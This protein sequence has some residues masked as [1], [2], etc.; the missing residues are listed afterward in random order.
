M[1][2]I[3]GNSSNRKRMQ[4]SFQNGSNLLFFT[5]LLKDWRVDR[6]Q[7]K[8]FL[9]CGWSNIF[10]L[11]FQKVCHVLCLSCSPVFVSPSIKLSGYI[12]HSYFLYS[13]LS[14][15]K[16][17]YK[18]LL[19]SLSESGRV[20]IE[21]SICAFY[22]KPPTCPILSPHPNSYFCLSFSRSLFLPT[23]FLFLCSM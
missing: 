3:T 15:R 20:K 22:H 10:H 2:Q 18:E 5:T 6:W 19:R 11:V 21:A 14:K 13:Y 23:P 16:L 12:A 4:S 8:S 17:S 1:E 9:L 7:K